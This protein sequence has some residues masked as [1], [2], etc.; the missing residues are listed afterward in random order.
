ME[1]KN[2]I[3]LASVFLVLVV[4]LVLVVS[5]LNTS[6]EADNSIVNKKTDGDKK[7][8]KTDGDAFTFEKTQ[9]VQLVHDENNVYVVNGE[10]LKIDSDSKGFEVADNPTGKIYSE[11]NKYIY[12]KDGNLQLNNAGK[13]E[14]ILKGVDELQR[15]GNY[16]IL[17]VAN[18]FGYYDI[19]N[20]KYTELFK[21]EDLEENQ[22][23]SIDGLFLLK[24][25]SYYA[26]AD[27]QNNTTTVYDSKEKVK[28]TTINSVAY[29]GYKQNNFL[30]MENNNKENFL[31]SYDFDADQIVDFKLTKEGVALVTKPE[32]GFNDKLYYYTA[33]GDILSL[34]FL[35]LDS[36]E[37]SSVDLK[38]QTDYIKTFEQDGY[39]IIQFASGF[40][41]TKGD[42]SFKYY[43]IP[44]DQISIDNDKFY[45]VK[46]SELSVI[47]GTSASEYS[48]K[49]EV[50][51]SLGFQNKFYY[52]YLTDE[53]QK[54][55]I[56]EIE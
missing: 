24:G 11:D 6:S 53:A 43:E 39:T 20:S 5:I 29:R 31:V 7:V 47:E 1:R 14:M 19:Q 21:K 41:Y 27:R 12:L 28:K 37:I 56:L 15:R 46:G 13:E 50:V 9:E 36:L 16:I 25:G 18:S 17:E 34:N 26:I 40:Y 54:L 3:T 32:L 4:V 51:S 44:F 23:V 30:L 42:D 8:V 45:I 48:L 55:E 10:V 22:H 33:K 38:P 35:N 2:I 49:G 52:T